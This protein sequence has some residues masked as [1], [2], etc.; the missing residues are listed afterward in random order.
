MGLAELRSIYKREMQGWGGVCTGPLYK[1]TCTLRKFISEPCWQSDYTAEQDFFF[2]TLI[3]VY[4]TK[5]LLVAIKLALSGSLKHPALVFDWLTSDGAGFSM[6]CLCG[7]CSWPLLDSFE[8][9]LAQY[10]WYW[11]STQGIMPGVCTNWCLCCSY[12]YNLERGFVLM[13]KPVPIQIFCPEDH[14]W[15][16][17]GTMGDTGDMK[18][19]VTPMNARHWVLPG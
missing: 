16:C 5:M 3:F 7:A 11:V 13:D 9:R 4:M 1:I 19:K 8:V 15:H 14:R 2:I 10:L 17:E 18:I 6:F 12:R